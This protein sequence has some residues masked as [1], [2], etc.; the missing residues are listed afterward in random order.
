[1]NKTCLIIA[2]PTASG[3]TDLAI[4][5][6]VK[7]NTEIISADSRQCYRELNIGVAKP[8]DAE[9][10]KVPHH[11]INTH[12]ITES[13]TAADFEAY[14][15][16]KVNRIFE[17]RDVVLMTGGTG[18]YIKA[19]ADGLDPVPAADQE[20]REGI[21]EAYT[22]F[23]LVWLQE[24]VSRLDPLYAEKGEMQNPRRIMRA[25]EVFKMTGAS[26]LHFH[27]KSKKEHPFRIVRIAIDR[28][29]EELYERINNRVD[30]MVEQGLQQEVESLLSYKECQAL[31]TVGYREWW[32]FFEG[33]QSL[34]EMLEKIR[35]NTRQYAKRQLTWFRHQDDFKFVEPDA[36]SILRLLDQ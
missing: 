21:S 2:G 30:R 6:G 31:Q 28:P 32:P 15:L 12:S 17:S 18:L 13:V 24:E 1:M 3:K 14:A 19:F 16:E 25:L 11:F 35:Q 10:E 23:G 27:E 4:E 5:L 29:R 33:E 36:G 8:T 26:I 7:L 34:E 9:L 20:I 22:K